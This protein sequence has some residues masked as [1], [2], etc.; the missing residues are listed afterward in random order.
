MGNDTAPDHV[1]VEASAAWKV[2]E[3][4]V[5]KIDDDFDISPHVAFFR[6]GEQIAS[7]LAL[8]VNKQHAIA[9]VTIG[10]SMLDADE[11]VVSMDTHVSS[12]PI[13]PKTG[14]S[15]KPGEMQNLCND[16]G[17]CDTGLITDAIATIRV[18]KD[19]P[20]VMLN[21]KYHV[22]HTTREVHWV[23]PWDC[24]IEHDEAKM[25]G[26]VLESFRAAWTQGMPRFPMPP[27][28]DGMSDAEAR[29]HKNI[30]GLR[31]MVLLLGGGVIPF[32]GVDDYL[33]FY[34]EFLTE[35][36][37]QKDADGLLGTLL[38]LF[39]VKFGLDE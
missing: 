9:A 38:P 13:N 6:D 2:K 11:V 17:A 3:T 34:K 32:E 39:R 7:F 12:N 28:P 19:V 18:G 29:V 30:A 35:E 33:D 27:K 36:Y 31:F 23:D 25:T 21:R 26:Y 5:D 8:E 4:G 24:A 20:T 15:W 10:A 37:V 16:E 14:E 22:N 1:L